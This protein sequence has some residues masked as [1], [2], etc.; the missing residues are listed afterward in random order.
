MLHPTG[1]GNLKVFFVMP[2]SYHFLYPVLYRFIVFY[3]VSGTLSHAKILLEL[4][5]QNDKVQAFSER[6]D[7]PLIPPLPRGRPPPDAHQ[8]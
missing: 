7:P 2:Q 8:E 3:V 6:G 5:L 1:L 4:L